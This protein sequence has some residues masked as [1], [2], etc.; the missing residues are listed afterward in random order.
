MADEQMA[1]DGLLRTLWASGAIRIFPIL[2]L[3]VASKN[4][5]PQHCHG[6]FSDIDELSYLVSRGEGCRL[7]TPCTQ[8]RVTG[9]PLFSYLGRDLVFINIMAKIGQYGDFCARHD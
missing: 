5:E 7:D 9:Y 1:S 6:F 8:I 2:F 4:F 3:Y